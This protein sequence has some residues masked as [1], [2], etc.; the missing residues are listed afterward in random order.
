MKKVFLICFIAVLLLTCKKTPNTQDTFLMFIPGNIGGILNG[1][2]LKFYH[3]DNMNELPD[4]ELTLPN[5]YD[6]VFEILSNEGAIG[7]VVGNAAQFYFYDDDNNIWNEQKD[8]EFALPNGYKDVFLFLDIAVGVVF[9]DTVKFYRYDFHSWDE[10]A[11]KWV[12]MPY[13]E[14]TLPSGYKSVFNFSFYEIARIGVVVGNTVKFYCLD[15]DDDDVWTE[16]REMEL[17]LPDKYKSV[18]K[19]SNNKMHYIRVTVGD[20]TKYYTFN[21]SNVWISEE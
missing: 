13:F 2:T 8:M 10:I 9:D 18:F 4:M 21:D 12:E 7:V 20:T 14:F 17:T 11:N 5:G 19:F 15:D 16:L 3:I 1:N 6:S